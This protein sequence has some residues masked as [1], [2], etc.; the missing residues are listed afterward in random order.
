MRR[1]VVAHVTCKLDARRAG[2]GIRFRIGTTDKTLGE[3]ALRRLGAP[4]RCF[5]FLTSE[6]DFLAELETSGFIG[7][8][9][10]WMNA[11]I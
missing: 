5:L 6:C 1:S 8:Q 7:V 2:C 4:Y 3:L 10:T 11:G 9:S